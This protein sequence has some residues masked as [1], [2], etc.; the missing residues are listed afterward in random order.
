MSESVDILGVAGRPVLHSRSPLLF[1]EMF[2]L[3]RAKA[4]YVRVAAGCAEEALGLFRALGMRGMN[5]TA[6]FKEAAASALAADPSGELSPEARSLGAVNCL[7]RAGAGPAGGVRGC[8][9]DPEGVLGGLASKG[10]EVAGRRCLVIGAGGAARAAVQA[11]ASAGGRVVVANRTRARA[12]ELAARFDCSSAGLES[13]P[14][15]AR[16]AELIV[17]TL[18]SESLPDPAGWFG[19]DCRAAVLDADYKSGLLWRIAAE[20]G[21]PAASG[22]DWLV[23]QAIP[24]YGLFM[25]GDIAG[26]EPGLF[27]RLASV[28]S[29]PGRDGAD[30][31][32]GVGARKI[33]LVGLMGAGKSS[34]GKALARLA[35]LPFVD[36]DKEIEAEAGMSVSR[37]F[38]L[39]GEASFRAREAR[40]IDRITSTPGPAVLST[41]GGALGSAAVTSALR[42][43]CLTVWLH[44]APE[45]A[46]ARAADGSRPLLAGGDPEVRLRALEAE[47][48]GAYAS[49]AE[50]LV[51]TEERSAAEVAEVIYEE[52]ARLS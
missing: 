47:R 12:D 36:A 42:E 32:G 46:A 11:I 16:G 23:G 48:R 39:E 38:E 15:L 18:A 50:L 19:P 8:N 20:R 29:V 1:R 21:L 6:P 13:L 33:A 44:V 2:R 35:R 22:A 52:I 14:E 43:R 10:I 7:A 26:A 4:A 40:V 31:A 34:V 51:S 24:A 17:S 9:T 37:I 45:T 49:A 28:L 5:L 25:G 30:Y 27:G 41:G 3:T